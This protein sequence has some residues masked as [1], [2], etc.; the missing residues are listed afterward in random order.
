MRQNDLAPSSLPELM[1]RMRNALV[2]RDKAEHFGN[3]KAVREAEVKL[4]EII[5]EAFTGRRR[6]TEGLRTG[7]LREASTEATPHLLGVLQP[8]GQSQEP[9]EVPCGMEELG[10]QAQGRV[11]REMAGGLGE[12]VGRAEGEEGGVE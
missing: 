9:G 6:D 8:G 2:A 7:G 3:W 10:A 1:T 4:A 5:R 11:K 12:R